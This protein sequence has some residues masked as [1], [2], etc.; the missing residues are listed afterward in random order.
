MEAIP[1]TYKATDI[2]QT[3]RYKCPLC[4]DQTTGDEVD[5]G[6]VLC[7]MLQ[8]KPICLGCC[9]DYQNVARLEDFDE[10][11]YHDLFDEAAEKT[12]KAAVALRRNCLAH[13]E[14]ILQGRYKKEVD[15]GTRAEILRLLSTVRSRKHA[16]AVES[17]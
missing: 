11:P 12:G 3:G 1:E 14:E 9:L 17:Q 4:E 15:E 2:D 8:G 10:N 6:W 13:Q 7:P 16:I 5:T